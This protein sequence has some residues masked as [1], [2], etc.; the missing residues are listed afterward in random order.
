M[1]LQRFIL[2]L[3]LLVATGCTP[4]GGLGAAA[5]EL[6]LSVVT[7]LAVEPALAPEASPA[8]P[9]ALRVVWTRDL[10]DGTDIFSRGDDLVLMGFDSRDDRGEHV[11]LSDPSTYAKPLITPSGNEIVF[12]MRREGTVHAILWNGSGRRHVADGFALAVWVDPDTGEEWVYVGIDLLPTDPPSYRAV[13][14]HR[15]DN[16]RISE[17][18]WDKQPVSD[19]SFQLSADGRYAAAVFPWPNA[20]VADLVTGTWER[21]GHGCWTAIANDESKI[22]WYFDAQHRNVTMVNI[23]TGRRWKVDISGAPGIDGFEVYHPRWTNHPRFFT[24]TGPYT[25]GNHNNKIRGGGR[26]VEIY[27]GTFNVDL[28]AVEQW[29]RI[30]YNDAPDFYPDAWIEP[31][32]WS[33][34]RSSL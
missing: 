16:P 5:D 18:I 17:L 9:P 3:A 31:D 13:N 6:Q 25:V 27:V 29:T 19:D 22:V 8:R 28:T 26:Q 24:V 1:K 11:I 20:G 15:I 10:G 21:L 33:D 12:S 4:T 30:T 7:L 23:V 14:R 2:P 34:D 32:A